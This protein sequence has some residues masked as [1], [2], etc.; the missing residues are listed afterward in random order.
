[1]AE[2]EERGRRWLPA[3]LTGPALGYSAA[4]V[5]ALSSFTPPLILY[6]MARLYNFKMPPAATIA[7]H[8]IAMVPRHVMFRSL[9]LVVATEVKEHTNPWVAFGAIGITQGFVYGMRCCCC[10]CCCCC[11]CC[12]CVL[13]LRGVFLSCAFSF[14]VLPS[15]ASGDLAK[16]WNRI[17]RVSATANP[18]RGLV[19]AASRDMLSQGVPFMVGQTYGLGAVVGTA[20]VSTVASHG[21]HNWQTVMQIH[22]DLGYKRALQKLAAMHG[23][24]AL[25]KGSLSRVGIMVITNALNFVLLRHA[26]DSD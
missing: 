1:M 22:P 26:W 6:N 4:Y 14:A 15:A 2:V 20:V 9:Q 24:R 18:A 5:M 3:A 16:Q 23:W 19:A 13:L 25:Y 12:C 7:R 11:F 21:L 17:M 8:S 10:C